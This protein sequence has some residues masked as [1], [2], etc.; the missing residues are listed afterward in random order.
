MDLDL[1]IVSPAVAAILL[2][3][4]LVFFLLTARHTS[5]GVLNGRNFTFLGEVVHKGLLARS[6]SKW[7]ASDTNEFDVLI[8][9]HKKRIYNF[10]FYSNKILDQIR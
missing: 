9:I 6:P 8:M 4:A 2:A 3:L 7:S 1:I 10:I 5:L